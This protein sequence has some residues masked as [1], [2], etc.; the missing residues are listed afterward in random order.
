MT[1]DCLTASFSQVDT[2]AGNANTAATAGAC[3]NFSI[4][5]CKLVCADST[6]GHATQRMT[7]LG[8]NKGKSNALMQ[9]VFVSRWTEAGSDFTASDDLPIAARGMVRRGIGINYSAYSQA[10]AIQAI[11]APRSSGILYSF[12]FPGAVVG[13]GDG[14]H[15]IAFFRSLAARRGNLTSSGDVFGFDPNFGEY[16]IPVAHL[17]AWFDNLKASYAGT[18]TYQYIAYISPQG[19]SF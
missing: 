12:W 10:A 16:L 7:A 13:A 17:D 6:P 5:W 18:I 3:H 15:T 19:A 8:A 14:A 1:Q 2:M 9:K 11:N 4:E